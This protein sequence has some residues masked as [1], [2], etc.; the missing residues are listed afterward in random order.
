M[1][2][3]NVYLWEK[4]I[5][6]HFCLF[7]GSVGIV[8]INVLYTHIEIIVVEYIN[9]ILYCKNSTEEATKLSKIMIIF[10]LSLLSFCN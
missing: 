9:C 10:N 3:D 7:F 6:I 5:Y 8:F 1:V 4:E 2:C